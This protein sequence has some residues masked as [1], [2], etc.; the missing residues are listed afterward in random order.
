[1]F[2]HEHVIVSIVKYVLFV[3]DSAGDISDVYVYAMLVGIPI[4]VSSHRCNRVRCL[5]VSRWCLCA[6]NM[7]GARA[8]MWVNI[9]GMSNIQC[10]MVVKVRWYVGDQTVLGVWGRREVPSLPHMCLTLKGMGTHKN[11]KNRVTVF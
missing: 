9:L 2:T 4:L 10:V 6:S 3:G 11:D 1:M 8:R 7:C 5:R